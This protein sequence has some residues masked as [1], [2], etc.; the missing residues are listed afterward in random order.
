MLPSCVHAQDSHFKTN[1]LK[2]L[3]I[4]LDINTWDLLLELAYAS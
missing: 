3:D 4:L 2:A 1:L